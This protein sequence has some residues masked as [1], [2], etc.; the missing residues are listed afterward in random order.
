M[1]TF[2]RASGFHLHLNCLRPDM[3]LKGSVQS[4]TPVHPNFSFSFKQK[5]M[6]NGKILL[7]IWQI[8][9]PMSSLKN[10][11]LFC[12]CSNMAWL[13]TWQLVKLLLLFSQYLFQAQGAIS[14]VIPLSTALTWPKAYSLVLRNQDITPMM[15]PSI[16]PSI[17]F[18]P[19]LSPC[20]HNQIEHKEVR[21]CGSSF[22]LMLMHILSLLHTNV[23]WPRL[24]VC[25]SL[26]LHLLWG[27][28]PQFNLTLASANPGAVII[29]IMHHKCISWL[30]MTIPWQEQRLE[31]NDSV[32][33][34]CV[35]L[36]CKVP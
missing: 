7:Q 33:D 27:Y 25:L 17:P 19:S 18:N 5:I 3:P 15:P 24:A 4:K 1:P 28:W 34:L 10:F 20:P 22:S 21:S 30:W 6:M 31:I 13:I 16:V 36:F 32:V 9:S 8:V 12:D 29:F 26:D 35:F 14:S 11:I 23:S 2:L